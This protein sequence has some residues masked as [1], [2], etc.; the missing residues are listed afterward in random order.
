[1]KSKLLIILLAVACAFCLAFS[2]AACKDDDT[3]K[4]DTEQGN[5]TPDSEEN[6]P[7]TNG[8][9]F[10][11][12][13]DGA[14][15]SVTGV[16]S[17]KAKII[18]IPAVYSNKPVT[19]IG[20]AA[21]WGCES[22]ER[23]IIPNGVTTIGEHAFLRCTSLATISI[24]DSVTTI[25]TNA[26]YLTAYYN[27]ISNWDNGV[28]YISNHLIKAKTDI[29]D[30]YSIKEGTRTIAYAALED[31]GKLTSLTI[32]NSVTTIGEQ[33]FEDCKSLSSVTF[34]ENSQL[35]SIGYCA[36]N[37]CK[38]LLKIAL[39]N[40]VT[41]L[42]ERV[43]E[44]C[45]SLVDIT[46]P[47]G[48]TSIGNYA[49]ELCTSLKNI[50]IPDGVTYIGMWAFGSCEGLESITLPSSI[51]YIDNYA[52]TACTSLTRINYDGTTEQWRTI[53]T[54]SKWDSMTAKYTIY[55]TDGEIAQDGTVTQY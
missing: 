29:S 36:F 52:I 44:G 4:N 32:P 3:P 33:A 16:G 11:L 47:D 1:M 30:S 5:N 20:E 55:C 51:I 38:S 54:S 15:Y 12:N 24:P 31:C 23:V 48:I 39:P 21:F 26:F 13:D 7:E 40:S 10:E 37:G 17:V 14:S 22:L 34:D 45:T 43:F 28:L 49:F 25:L 50:V 18:K 2:F 19:S 42:G 8:L 6:I 46:L 27:D 53:T 41:S 35:T 9:E